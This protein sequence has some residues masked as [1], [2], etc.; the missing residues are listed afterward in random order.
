MNFASSFPAL[1]FFIF[2]P[3]C[4]LSGL[5]GHGGTWHSSSRGAVSAHPSAPLAF[6]AYLI[7]NTENKTCWCLKLRFPRA[8]SAEEM[9]YLLEGIQQSSHL[10]QCQGWAGAPG[11]PRFLG[12]PGGE[13]LAGEP[14]GNICQGFCGCSWRGSKADTWWLAPSPM[15]EEGEELTLI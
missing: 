1:L 3:F 10:R 12:A 11:A 6:Q 9:L 14:D 7:N 8:I 15:R 2:F 5:Q 13:F 4:T